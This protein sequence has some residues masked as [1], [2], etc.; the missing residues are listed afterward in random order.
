MNVALFQKLVIAALGCPGFSEQQKAVLASNLTELG[1]SDLITGHGMN[2]ALGGLA[3]YSANWPFLTL[4]P[5]ASANPELVK[6]RRSCL[7]LSRSFL[8]FLQFY[9][10]LVA[11]ATRSRT[12][13][14]S[15]FD[16]SDEEVRRQPFGNL[17]INYQTRDLAGLT[18]AKVAKIE[19]DTVRQVIRL[20]L[21]NGLSEPFELE[22]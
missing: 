2:V 6:V 22:A 7:R 1:Y 17:T 3:P 11:Q 16:V 10:A 20:E 9:A 8:T 13:L 21:V 5:K 14:W 15:P 4:C 12:S 18:L 19:C